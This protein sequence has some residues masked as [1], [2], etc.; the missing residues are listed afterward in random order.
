MYIA[1]E[2]NIGA[3][4]STILHPLANH[5][6]FEVIEEGIETDKGFQECLAEF[7]KKGDK[8]SFAALQSYL[9]NY[10]ANII[11]NLDPNK[12]YLMERSL[13]GAVLFS[14]AENHT[15]TATWILQ[16]FKHVPQPAHYIY[17][18]CDAEI[19]AQRIT[20]RGRECEAGLPLDYLKRVEEAHRD[21]AYMAEWA[22]LATVVDSSK[23]VKLEELAGR[24]ETAIR[25][26]Q[27]EFTQHV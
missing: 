8:E 13:Q 23:V 11:Q 16:A 4:K 5:L 18:D 20:K 2:G 10:R 27:G 19:C 25:V 17:L 12:N 24:V 1:I 21:W 9:A 14:I 15:D 7:Y 3:G 22:G 6:G 26:K